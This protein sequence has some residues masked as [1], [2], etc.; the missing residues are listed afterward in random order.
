MIFYKK[1]SEAQRPRPVDEGSRALYI[2]RATEAN[3]ETCPKNCRLVRPDPL[4]RPAPA[5]GDRRALRS[6]CVRRVENEQL[7]NAWA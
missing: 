5:E 7:L 2:I 4:V 1:R 6:N 3:G